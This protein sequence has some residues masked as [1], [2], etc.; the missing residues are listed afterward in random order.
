M[1]SFCKVRVKHI[2]VLVCL[3]IT[4]KKF[5][6]DSSACLEQAPWNKLLGTSSLEQAEAC[7]KH[8]KIFILHP[9][10]K[11][12]NLQGSVRVE[13]LRFAGRA[14]VL[15]VAVAHVAQALPVVE[16]QAHRA[17]GPRHHHA[18]LLAV[19]DVLDR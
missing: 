2:S 16:Q 15:E 4:D 12:F 8:M 6:S 9:P 14:G 19:R 5:L 1:T 18:V 10:G 13:V 7:S 3:T 17:V 11:G